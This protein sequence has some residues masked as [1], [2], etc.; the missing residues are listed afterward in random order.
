MS[1]VGNAVAPAVAPVPGAEMAWPTRGDEPVHPTARSAFTPRATKTELEIH[2]VGHGLRPP[3]V[4]EVAVGPR[5]WPPAMPASSDPRKPFLIVASRLFPST[6]P[7][8][9]DRQQTA[10]DHNQGNQNRR[11]KVHASL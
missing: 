10:A 2:G 11:N 6:P 7:K 9:E 5:P 1:E 4:G 3:P 8:Q